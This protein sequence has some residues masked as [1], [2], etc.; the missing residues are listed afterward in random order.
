MRRFISLAVL[1]CIS[2][3]A[4]AQN[5]VPGPYSYPSRDLNAPQREGLERAVIVRVFD[6]MH[7]RS[8]SSR[9]NGVEANR[10]R[11]SV[12]N[13]A[14]RNSHSGSAPFNYDIEFFSR[15][16]PEGQ[17]YFVDVIL[18][19][20]YATASVD[21]ILAVISAFN[22]DPT[23]PQDIDY[24]DHV[25]LFLPPGGG[26]SR[27]AQYVL[28]TVAALP[29]S[30][31]GIAALDQTG[32]AVFHE[33]GHG[34]A[35]GHAN[36]FNMWPTTG[37]GSY[38]TL[39]YG[40]IFDYMGGMTQSEWRF[41]SNCFATGV[42]ADDFAAADD[43]R[44]N[45]VRQMQHGWLG[46]DSVLNVTS[47]QSTGKKT[48]NG[49][50]ATTGLRAIVVNRQVANGNPES[51]MIYWRDNESLVNGGASIAIV[52]RQNIQAGTRLVE[53][54]Q[55]PT[56]ACT[57]PNA[58]AWAT[59]F[60]AI[61]GSLTPGSTWT[62]NVSGV[63]VLCHRIVYSGSTPVGLEVEIQPSATPPSFGDFPILNVI[64][65]KIDTR[66]VITS[67]T[68]DIQVEAAVP[69]TALGWGNI[70]RVE[71]ELVGGSEG[72]VQRLGLTSGGL[73]GEAFMKFTTSLAEPGTLLPGQT[74]NID[75]SK[76]TDPILVGQKVKRFV[77]LR[78]F[79]YTNQVPQRQIPVGLTFLM[80]N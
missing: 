43:I 7:V 58:P 65:S 80:N 69:S 79:A 45:P 77:R 70:D 31:K 34:Y 19:T 4:L 52:N 59:Y 20:H 30:S 46:T 15:S 41:D 62:D 25:V 75:V 51:L 1:L 36:T 53:F 5:G 76:L 13:L 68:I 29:A 40:D 21:Q 16:G 8:G 66:E 37:P 2:A 27:L 26:I 64:S 47:A 78:A 39:Q 38:E 55:G 35:C 67:G 73:N 11:Q 22:S 3:S 18:P 42:I 49:I 12:Q 44:A 57:P 74:W 32:A 61:S 6:P 33:M 56:V 63:S 28:F 71:V 24:Y 10:I 60:P 48:L 23:L 72:S 50:T 17:L 14:R 9:P 54:V